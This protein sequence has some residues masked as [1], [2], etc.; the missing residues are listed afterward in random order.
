MVV[1]LLVLFVL[2]ISIVCRYMIWNLSDDE[3]EE[4]IYQLLSNQVRDIMSKTN[5]IFLSLLLS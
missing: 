2:I 3:E 1:L 5:N 4:E